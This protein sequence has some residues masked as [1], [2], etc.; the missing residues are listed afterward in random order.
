MADIEIQ[1]MDPLSALADADVLEVVH[2]PAGNPT[3]LKLSGT[4]LKTTLKTYFD[5]L[6]NKYVHPN[7]SGDVTSVA[8]GAQTIINKAVTLV[9]MN[10][11]AT[12]SLLGRNTAETGVPEVLSKAT[13]LSLL[14]VEDGA[15]VSAD[16][17]VDGGSW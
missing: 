10:D 5:T 3:S 6:Y 13:A 2:D 17:V 4:N 9:K 16:M 7:H 12:A 14:N 15:D 1:E 11:M 8:D